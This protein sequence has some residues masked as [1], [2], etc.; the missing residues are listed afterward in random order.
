[1]TWVFGEK[2][3]GGLT[4]IIYR[5]MSTIYIEGLST[6]LFI[7]VSPLLYIGGLSTKLFIGVLGI[8]T[9]GPCVVI[10]TSLETLEWL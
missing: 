5:S 4:K 2:F 10:T 9:D 3:I 1:M 7:G 6:K 8:W